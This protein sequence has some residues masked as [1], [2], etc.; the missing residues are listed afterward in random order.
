M[1]PPATN[2]LTRRTSNRA[3]PPSK[4]SEITT[5]IDRCGL[6]SRCCAQPTAA[7]M[8][9]PPPSCTFINNSTGSVTSLVRSTTEVS[10]AARLVSIPGSCHRQLASTAE[11]IT[12]STMEPL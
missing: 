6:A 10:K 11:W 7:A 12:E 3:E 2:S 9:V 1:V 8:S 4:K 5:T